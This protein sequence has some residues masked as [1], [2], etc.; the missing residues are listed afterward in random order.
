M[1]VPTNIQEVVD[2]DATR[3]LIS[4]S[5]DLCSISPCLLL[6]LLSDVVQH[7]FFKNIYPGTLCNRMYCIPD[8]FEKLPFTLE[9]CS[10]SWFASAQ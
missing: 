6:R 4:L 1:V 8:N 10:Q 5:S 2:K 9:I 3:I 7:F